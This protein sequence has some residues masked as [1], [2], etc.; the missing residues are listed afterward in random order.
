MTRPPDM[1]R[2][3]D[4]IGHARRMEDEITPRLLAGFRATLDAMHC[5][6]GDAPGLHWCLAPDI[7]EPASLGRDGHPRPGLVLPDLGLPRRMWAGGRVWHHAPLAAGDR[8]TRI[9]TVLDITFKEG[10]TGRLGFVAVEHRYLRGDT[11]CLHEEQDIV[12]RPDPGTG[13]GTRPGTVAPSP[14]P[15]P[16]WEDAQARV[17]DITPTLLFR[18]SALTFNG[19]RIHYDQPYAT[20]TEGYGGLVVHGPMQATWMLHLA[21]DL[22]GRMPASFSYRGLSPLI[23]GRAAVVEARAGAEGLELRVRDQKANV[24]TMQASAL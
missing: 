24:V 8:I 20:G 6:G 4:W 5:A 10:R 15:A 22:L 19:H 2:P 23:C 16:L 21:R 18:Y 3:Q 11:L 9:S 14:P 17:P 1:T 13:T 12:Y 7:L